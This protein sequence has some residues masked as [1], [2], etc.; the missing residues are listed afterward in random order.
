MFSTGTILCLLINVAVLAILVGRFVF[1]IDDQTEDLIVTKFEESYD[2]IVVGSGSAGSVVAARLSE[3]RDVTVLVLE[4]GPDDRDKIHFTMPSETARSQHTKLDWEYYTEPQQYAC[5][6]LKDR[7]GYIPRGR[8]VGG[9]SQ[10]IFMAHV[11]GSRF[12]FDKWAANGCDGWS[13]EDVL[14][15][16]KK[17]EDMTDE[18]LAKS[19][20][21]SSSGPIKISKVAS[22]P[23]SDLFLRA[24]K[25]A[26][27]NETDHNGEMQEGG[28][29]VCSVMVSDQV[30]PG[31]SCGPQQENE[32]IFMLLPT[33]M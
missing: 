32:P 29:S 6:A 2:Y 14:P 11:R 4:A 19:E 30:L 5:G 15:Y 16:F 12:D 9:S 22:T 33:A 23:L 20:Y 1:P 28:S 7:R 21:H 24:A 8:V 17:Y 13:Y 3:D 10:L 25:E 31:D 27:Y 26:G 18:E